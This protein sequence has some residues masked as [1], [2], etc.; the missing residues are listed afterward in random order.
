MRPLFFLAALAISSLAIGQSLSLKPGSAQYV[1]VENGVEGMVR[2][3]GRVLL[4]MRVTPQPGKR[5]YAAGAR[6]FQPVA[7]VMTPHP[8]I[9]ASK[10]AYSESELDANSG[11]ATPVP[12]YKKTFRIAVPIVISPTLKHNDALTIGAAIN[13]QACDDR[14]CY[15]STSIPVLWK[16][17]LL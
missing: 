15:P 4:W 1:T 14:L 2:P 7:F 12:V 3:G 16:L 8:A 9:T 17:S 11:S 5:V 13:Y 6:D 10:P